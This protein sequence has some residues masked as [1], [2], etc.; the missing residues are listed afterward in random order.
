[1]SHKCLEELIHGY[2]QGAEG[3]ASTV[4][5]LANKWQREMHQCYKALI[6]TPDGRNA[7]LELLDDPSPHVQCWAG[8]HCLQWDAE[9][10]KRTLQALCDARGPCSFTAEITLAEFAKGRLSFDY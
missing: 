2:R 6:Q 9:R 10:A 3:T 4:P 1:M 7:L 5:Q 8:A